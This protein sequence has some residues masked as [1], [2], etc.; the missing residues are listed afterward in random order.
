MYVFM[1]PATLCHTKWHC[2]E[3]QYCGIGTVIASSC[4]TCVSLSEGTECGKVSSSSGPSS[5]ICILGTFALCT[6]G[7]VFPALNT[8][9][10][11]THLQI[12]ILTPSLLKCV[13]S[14]CS[15]SC[16]GLSSSNLCCEIELR[17]IRMY[18]INYLRYILL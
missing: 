5:L 7:D 8:G 14:G 4:C 9:V 10:L 15:Q 6:V 2:A 18:K 13:Y 17:Q 11:C 1:T 12:L 3:I 16:L